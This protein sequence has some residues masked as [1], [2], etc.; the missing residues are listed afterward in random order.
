MKNFLVLETL[1]LYPHLPHHNISNIS[2]AFSFEL[3]PPIKS[4]WFTR[5]TDDSGVGVL[6][7]Y[8]KR[9]IGTQNQLAADRL[10]TAT[11]LQK[12]DSSVCLI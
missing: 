2:K 5:G 8:G 9:K 11:Y 3:R 12:Y 1:T 4:I 10:T 7:S 6:V